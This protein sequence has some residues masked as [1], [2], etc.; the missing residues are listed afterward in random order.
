M[1]R[2][3]IVVEPPEELDN[4]FG[5]AFQ[6]KELLRQ[7]I[8]HHSARNEKHPSAGTNDYRSLAFIGDAALKYAVS[9]ILFQRKKINHWTAEDLHNKTIQNIMNKNLATIAKNQ[10]KLDRFLVRGNGLEIVQPSMYATCLEAIIGVIAIDCQND[11]PIRFQDIITNILQCDKWLDQL[12][13]ELNKVASQKKNRKKRR[14]FQKK[15]RS[16]STH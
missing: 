4:I 1:P 13:T 16:R 9:M 12:E 15:N 7:A 5:H 8:T 14:N 6:N 2:S 11:K 3:I 10:L